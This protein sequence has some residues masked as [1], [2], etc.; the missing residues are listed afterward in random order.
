MEA[1]ASLAKTYLAGLT[2]YDKLKSIANTRYYGAP[3]QRL[4]R[5]LDGKTQVEAD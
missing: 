3:I 2:L 4:R 1:A 5:L